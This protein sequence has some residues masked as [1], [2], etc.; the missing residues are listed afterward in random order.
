MG[1]TSLGAGM[2]DDIGKD[3]L[4]G[5]VGFEWDEEK[6]AGN[7]HKHGI[8]FDEASEVFYRPNLLHRSDRKNE[9]RWLAVGESERRIIAVV[10]VRR[11]DKLCTARA[12]K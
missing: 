10:C 6:A 7:L 1:S 2:S 9:E 3:L 5:I 8:D 4:V 11:G 12:K